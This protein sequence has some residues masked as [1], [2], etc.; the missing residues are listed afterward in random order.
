MSFLCVPQLSCVVSKEPTRGTCSPVLLAMRSAGLLRP[1]IT[2]LS[3]CLVA[4]AVLSRAWVRNVKS[5][6][7]FFFVSLVFFF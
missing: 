1:L 5:R 3:T 7:P 6:V 4:Y 2:P